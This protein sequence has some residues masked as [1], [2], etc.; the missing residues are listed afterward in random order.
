MGLS[1]SL[2]NLLIRVSRDCLAEKLTADELADALRYAR[3]DKSGATLVYS[4]LSVALKRYT[5]I[6]DC[7]ST[8]ATPQTPR[9]ERGQSASRD[10]SQTRNRKDCGCSRNS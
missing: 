3:G 8:A 7:G 5:V 9:A 4:S 6:A 10:N 2:E 1:M